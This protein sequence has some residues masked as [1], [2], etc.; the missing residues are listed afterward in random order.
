MSCTVRTANAE[1]SDGAEIRPAE[2]LDEL[3]RLAQHL[4]APSFRSSYRRI[5]PFNTRFINVYVIDKMREHGIEGCNKNPNGNH[6]PVR[7]FIMPKLSCR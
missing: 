2:K 1:R 5:S 7:V 6:L 4:N 3:I